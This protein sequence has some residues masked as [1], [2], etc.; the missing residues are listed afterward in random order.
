MQLHFKP[1]HFQDTKVNLLFIPW[2]NSSWHGVEAAVHG[3]HDLSKKIINFSK[4][5]FIN[6]LYQTT[7]KFSWVKPLLR[8]PNSMGTAQTDLRIISDFLKLIDCLYHWH[9][10]DAFIKSSESDLMRSPKRHRTP[11]WAK[12]IDPE[13]RVNTMMFNSSWRSDCLEWET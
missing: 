4:F 7:E 9:S 1:R 11:N 3:S 13:R 8:T 2:R 5:R 10:Y 6:K 12:T